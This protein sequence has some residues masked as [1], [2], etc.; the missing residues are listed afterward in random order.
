MRPAAVRPINKLPSLFEQLYNLGHNGL[1]LV[2][3]AEQQRIVSP[4]YYGKIIEP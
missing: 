1:G 4:P 2:V 3:T